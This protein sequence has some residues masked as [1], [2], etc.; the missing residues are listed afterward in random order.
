MLTRFIPLIAVT[1]FFA[2][3]FLWR[4]WLQRRRHGRTGVIL[5]HSRRW[6]QRCRDLLF[7]ALWG[8]TSVQAI[9]AATVPELVLANRAWS[10]PQPDAATAAGAMLLA[11]GLLFLVVAQLQLG[12]SWRIGIE[13]DARPGLVVHG[14]YSVSR[15][16]IFLGMF[17]V[18]AGLVVLLPTW[19]SLAVLVGSIWCVRSQVLEEE[20]YLSGAYGHKYW[21]YAGV[22]G[23]FVP[24][25]GRLAGP[26]TQ[27]TVRSTN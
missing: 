9:A 8:A 4:A 12:Q 14:L 10:W 22:V 2:I 13:E 25:L 21:Q 20:A 3:G 19:L 7:I 16:P 23:R 24:G 5:F 17:T 15:N 27:R 6:D 18:L 11:V 1:L 26:V